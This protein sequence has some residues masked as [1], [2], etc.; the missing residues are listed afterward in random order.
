MNTVGTNGDLPLLYSVFIYIASRKKV[1][2]RIRLNI[3]QSH[4]HNTVHIAELFRI[5]LPRGGV[6]GNNLIVHSDENYRF[7]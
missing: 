1:F 7:V 3:V 2:V 4:G 5:E 6:A